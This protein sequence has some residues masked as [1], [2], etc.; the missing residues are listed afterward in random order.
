[1]GRPSAEVPQRTTAQ[2][3]PAMLHGVVQRTASRS[4]GVSVAP[5]G[6]AGQS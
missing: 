1:M 4:P 5:W 3:Q 2:G 6:G